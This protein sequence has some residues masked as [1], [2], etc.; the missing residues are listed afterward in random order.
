MIKILK[1]KFDRDSEAEFWCNFKSSY[2]GERTLPSGSLCLCNVS[3]TNR[4]MQLEPAVFVLKIKEL[5]KVY[6][7]FK[8]FELICPGRIQAYNFDVNQES[9]K[10]CTGNGT[11]WGILS[12]YLKILSISFARIPTHF[13][14]YL[15]I[16]SISIAQIT[17]TFH[18]I[19]K[20]IINIYCTNWRNTIPKPKIHNSIFQHQHF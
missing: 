18:I 4:L 2:F 15:K 14:Y 12:Y 6:A 9:T 19:L 20:Y 3:L 5:H 8:I 1:L 16:L 7:F 11:W 13:S 10:R 17:P